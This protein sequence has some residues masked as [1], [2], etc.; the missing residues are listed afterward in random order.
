MLNVT[1]LFKQWLYKDEFKKILT[2]NTVTIMVPG[3]SKP[4]TMSSQHCLFNQLLDA[5]ATKNSDA[6]L[7]VIA[8]SEYVTSKSGGAVA[9]HS[10]VVYYKGTPCHNIVA[11]RILQSLALGLSVGYLMRFLERV[12]Q[13]PLES[14]RNELFLFLE[15]GNLP[16]REDGKFIAYKWVRRDYYDC[17]SKTNLHKVGKV[18]E[19]DRSKVDPSRVQ[20]CSYGLHVC[21]QSYTR[22]GERL[23]EVVVAPEDVVAVPEDYNNA[24]M[25]TCRYEVVRELDADTYGEIKQ[26]IYV[27]KKE[28]FDYEAFKKCIR[29]KKSISG[30]NL[31]EE[32][33]KFYRNKA[34]M[35]IKNGK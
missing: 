4:F 7:N 19:M 32:D 2:A 25:R 14:A 17:H 33:L 20:T 6:V 18:I 15:N 27:P 35:E 13:N 23:L 22:F 1:K 3:R 12:M 16:I 34:K 8:A 24:K 30:F 9:I 10:G 5:I 21:T 11:S 31:S 29:N 28:G 26:A